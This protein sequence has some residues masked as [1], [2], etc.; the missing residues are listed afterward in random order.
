MAY[1][2]KSFQ[3]FDQKYKLVLRNIGKDLDDYFDRPQ[4]DNPNKDMNIAIQHVL[5]NP[6]IQNQLGALIRDVTQAL[7]LFPR[8]DSL[9]AEKRNEIATGKK[10]GSAP[11]QRA[12]AE[13]IEA[14]MADAAANSSFVDSMKQN[15]EN[16]ASA[17][18]NDPNP[19]N[20]NKNK[21]KMNMTPGYSAKLENA[22]KFVQKLV[23]DVKNTYKIRPSPMGGG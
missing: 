19:Q 22:P 16:T 3:E 6:R 23:Q 10:Q 15:N 18:P 12:K 9:S 14:I 5:K 11:E 7:L 17:D 8:G 2:P 20:Q 4:L 21:K 13:W 1:V